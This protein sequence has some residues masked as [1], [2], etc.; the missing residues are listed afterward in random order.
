MSP[1]NGRTAAYVLRVESPVWAVPSFP[2][3]L[4]ILL[5]VKLFPDMHAAFL[6]CIGKPKFLADARD[7]E[8]TIFAT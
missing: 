1:L 4:S 8:I 3:A 5:R 6:P 2:L 7:F